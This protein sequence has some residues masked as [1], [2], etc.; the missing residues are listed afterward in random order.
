MLDLPPI[1]AINHVLAQQA[2]ARQRLMAHAGRSIAVNMPPMPA[3]R[4]LIRE[5]GLLKSGATT[6]AAP[7]LSLELRAASLPL[8]LARD[9]AA[10]RQ[11]GFSGSAD[12]AQTVQQLFDQLEWDYEDDLAKVFGDVLG[13]RIAGAGREFFGWQ[14]EAG[15][16]LAQNLA[17]FWTEEQ[18]LI[19]A[20]TDLQRF[21]TEVDDLRDAVERLEK[22]IAQLERPAR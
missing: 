3:L 13:R 20:R 15:L 18:P 17:E 11:V 2:W 1:A 5:D 21:A 7:D 10:I 6:S 16:R 14:R 22:R 12:L 19:A 9:P 8:L 4:V